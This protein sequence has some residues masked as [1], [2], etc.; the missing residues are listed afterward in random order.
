ME[1]SQICAESVTCTSYPQYLSDWKAVVKMWVKFIKC[2]CQEWEAEE[3]LLMFQYW[4]REWRSMCINSIFATATNNISCPLYC[5][6]V[7]GTARPSGH[8]WPFPYSTLSPSALILSLH[9]LEL[10]APGTLKHQTKPVTE[11]KR[12]HKLT[13]HF[14]HL[15]Y[16][17]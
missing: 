4:K 7:T 3:V 11:R 13:L 6:P 9:R 17:L 10:L 1:P 5:A 2:L 8:S 15:K 14:F 16:M 12:L